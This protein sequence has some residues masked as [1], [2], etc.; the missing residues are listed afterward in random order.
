MR[1]RH[2]KHEKHKT[3]YA[4]SS[5]CF[6]EAFETGEEHSAD[7][8]FF[9]SAVAGEAGGKRRKLDKRKKSRTEKQ[10]DNE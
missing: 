6:A 1:K 3:K 5:E 10:Y 2:T 4:K 9:V 7:R 8:Y